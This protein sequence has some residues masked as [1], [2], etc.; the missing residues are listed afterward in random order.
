MATANLC[1]EL[2]EGLGLREEL[3]KELSTYIR[4]DVTVQEMCSI[5]KLEWTEESLGCQIAAGSKL[6]AQFMVRRRWASITYLLSDLCAS[7]LDQYVRELWT[8]SR[9]VSCNG[10]EAQPWTCVPTTRYSHSRF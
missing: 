1:D 3:R 10:C 2:C 9:S 6:I 5:L 4:R 7:C 8:S